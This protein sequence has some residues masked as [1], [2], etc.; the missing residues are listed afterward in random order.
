IFPYL[1]SELRPFH[2]PR[3]PLGAHG[4]LPKRDDYGSL[5]F[6]EVRDFLL[7]PLRHLPGWN[8]EAQPSRIYQA[9]SK[10]GVFTKMAYPLSSNGDMQIRF[11]YPANHLDRRTKNVRQ[12]LIRVFHGHSGRS[13]LAGGDASIPPIPDSELSILH[14]EGHL[15]RSFDAMLTLYEF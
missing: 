3:V 11:V 9:I 8:L 15:Q 13:S 4:R 7:G 10:V 5:T 1:H 12:H 2:F 6:Q 14:E